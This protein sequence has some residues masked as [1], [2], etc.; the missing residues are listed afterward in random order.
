MYEID[1]N[2]PIPSLAPK[3]RKQGMAS[4]TVLYP[5]R[6]M[7][8]GDSFLVPCETFDDARV[9]NNI[10]LSK[11]NQ[12]S[13]IKITIRRVADGLRVWRTE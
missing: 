6:L 7:E 10:R 5:F 11:Q 12:K 4:K 13:L 9:R 3:G 1:K 8:I 2:I